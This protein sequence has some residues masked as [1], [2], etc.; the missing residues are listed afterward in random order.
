MK[1]GYLFLSGMHSK[2]LAGETEVFARYGITNRLEIGIGYL[3]KQN[4]V[5]PLGSY[6]LSPEKPDLPSITAGAMVDSLDGGRQMVFLSAGKSF[7]MSNGLHLSGYAGLARVTTSGE[8]R[9]IGGVGI[10]LRK[11]WKLSFQY[12][13]KFLNP[14]LTTT[15]KTKNGALHVGIVAARGNRFGPLI[16]ASF[17]LN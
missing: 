11:D 6:V 10:P 12:D 17:P 14:G 15:I 2:G 4:I 5:R 13:G 3:R 9:F 7:P 1:K 16:A 8:N